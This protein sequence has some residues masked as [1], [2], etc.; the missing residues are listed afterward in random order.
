MRLSLVLLE[1]VEIKLKDKNYLWFR[2]F[3]FVVICVKKTIKNSL[4]LFLLSSCFRRIG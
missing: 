2:G 3:K 4:S 1:D